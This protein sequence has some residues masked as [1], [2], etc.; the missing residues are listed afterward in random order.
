MLVICSAETGS[1]FVQ[2]GSENVHLVRCL[3]DEIFGPDN[4]VAQI[5]FRKRSSA[6]ADY[7][8][9]VNDYILWYAK[10]YEVTKYAAVSK[11]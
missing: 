10:K 8:S 1:I 9:E 2:I 6:T 7:I 3:L 5:I 11:K 4:Y